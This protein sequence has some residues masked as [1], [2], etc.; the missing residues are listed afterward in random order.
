MYLLGIIYMCSACAS[1]LYENGKFTWNDQL[2]FN[3]TQ[4]PIQALRF[5]TRLYRSYTLACP[6]I[7][8]YS[9]TTAKSG[10]LTG[11]LVN[12]LKDPKIATAYL[13]SSPGRRPCE[14]LPS[15]GIRRSPLSLTIFQ[16]SSLLI[17][18]DQLKSNLECKN[19]P[20]G[21]LHRTDVGI[22]DPTKNMTAVTKNR[23]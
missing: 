2:A 7:Y 10:S 6:N 23:P 17:L 3:I 18:L 13:F 21:I 16:N 20:L 12:I 5:V 11:P 19:V 1:Y 14:L 8:E 22:F 9:L 15:L 4:F